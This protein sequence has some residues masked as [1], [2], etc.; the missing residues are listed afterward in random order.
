MYYPITTKLIVQNLAALMERPKVFEK[1]QSRS[2]SDKTGGFDSSR[3][4]G[5]SSVLEEAVS[6]PVHLSWI[7]ILLETLSC[8][9]LQV[10][11]GYGEGMQDL[12]ERFPKQWSYDAAVLSIECFDCN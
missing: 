12:S 4:C 2:S 7:S 6:I 10:Q 1:K 9:H 3:V 11:W 5:L 8:L